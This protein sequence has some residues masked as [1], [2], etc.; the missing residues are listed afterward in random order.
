MAL[1]RN[2]LVFCPDVPET[3]IDQNAIIYDIFF[4]K[5]LFLWVYLVLPKLMMDIVERF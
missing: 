1:F 4:A 5:W 3:E 2:I